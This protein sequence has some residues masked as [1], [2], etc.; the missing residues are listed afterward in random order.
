MRKI[1]LMIL[2]FAAAP[3]LR[4]MPERAADNPRQTLNEA[5]ALRQQPGHEFD[6]LI[7]AMGTISRFQ[8]L[9]DADGEGEADYLAG[10][11]LEQRELAEWYH[12]QYPMTAAAVN[13]ALEFLNRADERFRTAG[14][15][16]GL[17]K[18]AYEIGN[19][20]RS[21]GEAA[22][23]CDAYRL[24]LSRYTAGQ[25]SQRGVAVTIL[26]PDK[27]D[28]RESLKEAVGKYCA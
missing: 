12:A 10:L 1:L 14:D 3:A 5:Y 7:L 9:N 27:R 8:A 23:A 13:P 4:A 17:V 21:R 22:L 11:L 6:A 18:T 16:V 26:T 28:F 25:A 15:W 19:V 24:S 2:L 20:Q